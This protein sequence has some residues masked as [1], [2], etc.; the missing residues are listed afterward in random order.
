MPRPPYKR[1][2]LNHP[3]PSK[4]VAKPSTVS[5][6]VELQQKLANKPL[7]RVLT[8][9]DDSDKLVTSN[10]NGR[11]RRGIPRK[12]IY[13][14]G[15]VGVGDLPGAHRSQPQNPQAGQRPDA[16]KAP[17]K[18]KQPAVN[19]RAQVSGITKPAVGQEM[20]IAHVAEK[21]H[22]PTKSSPAALGSASVGRAPTRLQTTPGPETSI[23]G[24]IKPRRRQ[25][26]ILQ[27]L[28]NNDSSNI[29]E[30]DED[31]FLPN[32]ESTPLNHSA[33][34]RT[35]S[36]P[37]SSLSH[38]S[39][40]R[41]RKLSPP[42]T[43]VPASQVRGKSPRPENRLH[44]TATD[45]GESEP[46][47]PPSRSATG[48]VRATPEPYD[49]DI[50]A[51]P[52]SSSPLKSPEKPAIPSPVKK[53]PGK[54]RKQPTAPSTNELRALM[55]ARR[56][57]TGRLRSK[58]LGE[59]DIPA[60]TDSDGGTSPA[61]GSEEGDD[62]SFRADARGRKSKPAR[63]NNNDGSKSKPAKKSNPAR[64]G[65]K[66]RAGR[67]KSTLS[68][69]KLVT[70]LPKGR[71]GGA[72]QKSATKSSLSQQQ[73]QHVPDSSTT[74]TATATAKGK[75]TYS[76]SSSHHRR[77]RLRLLDISGD[78]ENR[79]VDLS[80]D[81]SGGE[82][83]NPGDEE[84][85]DDSLEQSIEEPAK[86]KPTKEMAQLAKKFADVDEWEME[87]EDVSLGGNSSP[88]RR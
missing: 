38:Q 17:G 12:D 45:E 13:A 73:Q 64:T 84:D 61:V 63:K 39:I 76:S 44:T 4:R 83:G 41:K 88:N 33:A 37:N 25:P 3:T 35:T 6:V 77:R 81:F 82:A 11:N 74:T 5:P 62:L 30:E 26:S 79:P 43:L 18:G 72:S 53:P 8:D 29:G 86:T 52:L 50:M 31:D 46:E 34:Q 49:P 23:L 14:S 7:G 71:V 32:D 65:G 24:N 19:Q 48:P 59:F 87:F 60:D 55:P 2:K 22:L 15:G 70:P 28:E 20:Q 40:S 66:D 42:I 57:R 47:L 58:P 16:Q 56:Q 80:A 85:D 78:K 36:T 68:P 10:R 67:D 75:A 21:R 54:G 9:S 69:T 27:Q 51:P 1:A